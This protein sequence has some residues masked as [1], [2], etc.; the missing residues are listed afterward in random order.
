MYICI[1]ICIYIYIY[2][3]IYICRKIDAL[4]MM[5]KNSHAILQYFYSYFQ[6]GR[7]N[8]KIKFH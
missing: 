7:S 3:Y 2:I 4:A 5:L 6:I 1:Y 8:V